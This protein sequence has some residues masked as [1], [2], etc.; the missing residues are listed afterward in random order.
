MKKLTEQ[1]VNKHKFAWKLNEPS[2]NKI[3]YLSNKLNP[4]SC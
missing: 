2:L 3:I 1:L 4:C